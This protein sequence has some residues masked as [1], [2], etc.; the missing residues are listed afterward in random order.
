MGRPEGRHGLGA[1]GT[2]PIANGSA[3]AYA[4]VVGKDSGA[5]V[6]RGYTNV[7]APAPASA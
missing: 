7:G 4:S 5:G 3:E 6:H 1:C 2:E